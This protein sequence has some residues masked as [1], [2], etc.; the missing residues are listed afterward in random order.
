M[1]EQCLQLK[2][3][4]TESY[5]GKAA[6]EDE[7]RKLKELL[8]MNGIHYDSR[9]QS[10]SSGYPI[11][12]TGV[13]SSSRSAS[14]YAYASQSQQRLSP[15]NTQGSML[16]SPSYGST[17]YYG[18]QTALSSQS[19]LNPQ[20]A[21]PPLLSSQS[22]LQTQHSQQQQQQRQQGQQPQTQGGAQQVGNPFFN[23][24]LAVDFVLESVPHGA[25][26]DL[27]HTPPPHHLPSQNFP[28]SQY[29]RRSR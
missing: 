6:I 8:R 9:E 29:E 28:P 1:E 2:E 27:G 26:H 5:Q 20:S 10:G 17:E 15:S 21:V 25:S 23:D 19:T 22:G 14:A 3:L 7:N 4:C 16:N 18:D 13:S 11:D 24:Q 12:P